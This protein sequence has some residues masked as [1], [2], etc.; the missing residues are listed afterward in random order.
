VA[1]TD[2]QTICNWC[3][4][5]VAKKTW[6]QRYHAT[7]VKKVAQNRRAIRQRMGVL[8]KQLGSSRPVI[9]RRLEAGC[10]ACRMRVYGR[11]LYPLLYAVHGSLLCNECLQIYRMSW[12]T[13][14]LD[15]REAFYKWLAE[16]GLKRMEAWDHSRI[17]NP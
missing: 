7:C 1:S 3:D 12:G 9:K 4:K 2:T 6:R 10:E 14:P 15:R 8:E 17:D 11:G 13:I 5:P 16:T